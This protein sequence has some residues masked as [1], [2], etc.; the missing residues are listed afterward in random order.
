MDVNRNKKKH[1][2][3]SN[4]VISQELYTNYFQSL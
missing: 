3:P 1:D 4:K 2:F